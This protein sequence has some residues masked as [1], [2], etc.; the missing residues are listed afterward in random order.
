MKIK[1]LILWALVIITFFLC[2]WNSICIDNVHTF[3]MNISE[4]QDDIIKILKATVD[5]IDGILK[6]LQ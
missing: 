3:L 4:I 2:I 5:N 6:S 1:E